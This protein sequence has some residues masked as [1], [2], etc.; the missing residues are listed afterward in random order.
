MA[1]EQMGSSLGDAFGGYMGQQPQQR[2]MQGQMGS[3]LG[4]AFGGYMGQ[5]P[6]QRPMQGQNW[7]GFQQNFGNF[8]TQG[9]SQGWGGSANQWQ[10][11]AG[12]QPQG[13]N[14][15]QQQQPQ[16]PQ[17]QVQPWRGSPD[18][19]PPNTAPPQMP[20][21]GIPQGSGNSAVSAPQGDMRYRDLNRQQQARVNQ[22]MQNP[23]QMGPRMGG[24]AQIAQASMDRQQARGIDPAAM[25][26]PAPDRRQQQPMGG[27]R[28]QRLMGASAGGY[29]AQGAGGGQAKRQGGSRGV[30]STGMPDAA[31]QRQNGRRMRVR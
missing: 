22:L 28:Q 8:Q 31:L 19:P 21:P 20:Q 12:G 17:V 25:A 23:S 29:N 15:G 1:W 7:D 13:Q 16:Q 6:Q 18:T 10:N 26:R 27:G 9:P 30:M 2:P 4:S 24:V 3:S 14:W 11:A 5:R